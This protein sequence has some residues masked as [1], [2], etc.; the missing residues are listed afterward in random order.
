MRNENEKP[1]KGLKIKILMD[2]VCRNAA[3]DLTEVKKGDV[4]L[5][6]HAVEGAHL[7]A[8]GKAEIAA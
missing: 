1:A 5:D 8:M 3:G 2:T 6:A 4:M 7:V